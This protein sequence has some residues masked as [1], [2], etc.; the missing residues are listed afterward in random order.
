[1]CS[2]A[3]WQVLNPFSNTPAEDEGTWW[4][5]H[6]SAPF[7]ISPVDIFAFLSPWKEFVPFE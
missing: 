5:A 3:A 2:M 1:M 7:Q 4:D 6:S